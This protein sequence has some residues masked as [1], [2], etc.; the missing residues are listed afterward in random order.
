MDYLLKNLST[1]L[2]L[3]PFGVFTLIKIVDIDFFVDKFIY[4][5]NIYSYAFFFFG[6]SVIFKCVI[7]L[8]NEELHNWYSSPSII[9]I[10]KSRRMR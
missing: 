8:G 4:I 9:R 2:I 10:M 3:C 7:M 5:Y 6:V 1:C